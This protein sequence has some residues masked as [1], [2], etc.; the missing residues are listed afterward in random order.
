MS[1]MYDHAGV[2]ERLFQLHEW[3]HGLDKDLKWLS[4]STRL[5]DGILAQHAREAHNQGVRFEE[6]IRNVL[7]VPG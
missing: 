4:E 6:H 2:L 7:A 5:I 3:P 1:I